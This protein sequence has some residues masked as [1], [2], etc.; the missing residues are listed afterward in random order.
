MKIKGKGF[1]PQREARLITGQDRLGCRKI[2][3]IFQTKI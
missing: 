3:S 1:G 2:F